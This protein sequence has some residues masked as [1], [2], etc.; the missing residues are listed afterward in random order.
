MRFRAE[1]TTKIVPSD[2][3]TRFVEQLKPI[4]GNLADRLVVN[5]QPNTAH[6][7][8]PEMLKNSLHWFQTYLK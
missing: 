5:L 1:P 4:Y 3:A 7:F 6:R 8:T 2:G